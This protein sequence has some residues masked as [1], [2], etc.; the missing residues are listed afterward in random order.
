MASYTYTI[1][2]T[3]NGT[4]GTAAG[5]W[6]DPPLRVR[7]VGRILQDGDIINYI[8]V[9]ANGNSFG[10]GSITF[11]TSNNSAA[12]PFISNTPTITFTTSTVT[13]TVGAGATAKKDGLWSY[14]GV[15]QDNAGNTYTLADPEMQVGSGNPP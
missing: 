13:E 8:V 12:S 1:T 11:A 2:C 6:G 10:S 3:L 7:S 14:S 9:F 15:F 5:S 4:A